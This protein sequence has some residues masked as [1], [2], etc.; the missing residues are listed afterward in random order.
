[1]EVLFREADALARTAR[2]DDLVLPAR[3]LYG[4]E[5]VAVHN[6]NGDFS[7][8]QNVSKFAHGGLFD[9]AVFGCHHEITVTLFENGQDR[10]DLFSRIELND[11]DDRPAPRGAVSFGNLV[12]LHRIHFT[13]VGEE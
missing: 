7:A 13:E 1:M 12:A 11:I 2:N 10:R 4:N 5:L 6:L 3:E 9:N 8:P